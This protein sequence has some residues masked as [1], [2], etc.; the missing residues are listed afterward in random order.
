MNPRPITVR[1]LL[2]VTVAVAFAV[3]GCTKAPSVWPDRPGKKIMVSFAPLY[4]FVAKVAG[5]DANVLCLLTATGPHNYLPTMKD[6]LKL[7]EA[8]LLFVNGLGLDSDFTN[9]LAGS[10]DNPNLKVVRLGECPG[11]KD[12]L[13]AVD[14]HSEGCC[15]GHHHGG[16]DPHVWLGIPEAIA[17]VGCIR[18]ELKQA[19]PEHAASYEKRATDYIARLKQLQ[20]DGKRKF[21]AKKDHQFI[22]FHD[23]LQ[24][25]ARGLGL[26]VAASIQPQAG[27]EPD[28]GRLKKLIDVCEKEK[29]RVIAVEPQY[30]TTTSATTLLNE[31]RNRKV[32]DPVFAEVDPIE[33]APPDELTADY[34]EQRMRENIDHLA[35]ALR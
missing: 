24:Y 33:T 22:T 18:D 23:S 2:A 32:T 29:V 6:A 15:C 11:L 30:P 21:A 3:G 12:K 16:T 9:R 17:M 10:A 20:A 8:D 1:T 27:D 5:D 19:D 25:F 14:P 7:H 34:Y 13:R 4:C 28:P 35:G 31:L 26:K